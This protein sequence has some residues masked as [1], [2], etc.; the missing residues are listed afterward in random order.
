MKFLWIKEDLNGLHGDNKNGIILEL[1]DKLRLLKLLKY[2]E[3]LLFFRI[4]GLAPPI[5]L[6]HDTIEFYN[7]DEPISYMH[8]ITNDDILYWT[9]ETKLKLYV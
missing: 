6:Q 3:E 7:S 5:S 9:W 1:K 4:N 8:H 2:Q